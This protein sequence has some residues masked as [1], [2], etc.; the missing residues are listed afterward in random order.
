[1]SSAE[2]AAT[3]VAERNEEAIIDYLE[4]HPDFFERNTGLLNSLELP[5]STGGAA[6]SLV[7][8][9]VTVLR[10]RNNSL[11]KQL[12]DLV[13]VARS[14][15]E[16]AAK[17][18]SLSMLL[19]AATDRDEAVSI[20]ERELLTAFSV[21]R[22]VLVLF[23]S[24]ANVPH[25]DGGFLRLI[26]REDAAMS[27]F[28]T[29]LNASAARCGSVR[30]AQRDF[31]FGTENIDIGSVALIPLGDKTGFGFLAVGSH[32]ADHFHPGKSIDFLA[33]LGELITCV[34]EPRS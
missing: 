24:E 16:L 2:Q 22:A 20:L 19:L 34:L 3:D 31:L 27:P 8:R 12:R 10:Q 21:D 14:N 17:I 7:E 32:D 25:D 11:E 30:D 5:H 18:H 26:G 33:R 28:K 1:M 15:E 13:D 29:F 23:D 4:A 6:I 9:Q